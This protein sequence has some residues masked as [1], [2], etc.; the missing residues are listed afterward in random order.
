LRAVSVLS[1]ADPAAWSSLSIEAFLEGSAADTRRVVA[2]EDGLLAA[3]EA[4]GRLDE[5]LIRY[6][7]RDGAEQAASTADLSARIA[8]LS[9]GHRRVLHDAQRHA[10]DD[11]VIGL[12]A[13]DPELDAP[14]VRGL[15]GAGMMMPLSGELRPAGALGTALSAGG[16][17]PYTGRYRLNPD[18]PPP[19]PVAY[20]FSEAAMPLTEDLS[21]PS[22]GP[23]E[24]LHDMAALAA[25]LHRVEPRR[26]HA[27][28]LAR[29]DARRVARHLG[30]PGLASSGLLETDPR[31][32]RALRALE[33]LG[34]VSLS[35]LTRNLHLDLGLEHTLAGTTAAAIDRLVHRLVDRDQHVLLPAV[36]AALRVA[37]SGAVDVL[38]FTE[39]LQAQHR[40]VVFP[41]WRRGGLLVYPHL[42]ADEARLYDAEGFETVERYLLERLLRRIERLGLIRRAPGV[43]AATHDG[44]VWSAATDPPLPPVWV[45]SDME[46]M[47]PPGA[48]TP[49]ER[50]QLERLGRCLSRDVVNRYILEQSGLRAWL[51]WHDPEEIFALLRRRCPGIPAVVAQ[52]VEGWTAAAMRLVLTRG[53]LI[54]PP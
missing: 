19:P 39:Q 1:V 13:W 20:D 46:F 6:A 5:V 24:L 45:S 31:W 28:P 42:D 32:S 22:L 36:R 4:S 21:E 54:E 7:R 18:L 51:V 10:L 15:V 35:P 3:L 44:Q 52:T 25:A 30:L 2:D 41:G 53:V 47:V 34:A 50:F 38:I 26:T 14:L 29:I 43:F 11:V 16:E 40:S 9:G 49:W 33:A 27:G 37:G 48:V 17:E 8:A 12:H 23:I